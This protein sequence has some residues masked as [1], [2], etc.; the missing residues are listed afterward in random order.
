[1]RSVSKLEDADAFLT[2]LVDALN[3]ADVGILLLDRD[4]RVRFHNQRLLDMFSPALTVLQ[5]GTE[6][7]ELLTQASE[8][9]LFN[10]PERHLARFVDDQVA[11]VRAGNIATAR[12]GF[13]DGR[14]LLFGCAPCGDGGR[15]LTFTDIS[16]ELTNEAA[17]AV[18]QAS[19]DLRYTNEVIES[20]A[21]DL[22]TLAETAHEQA[23]LAER[24]RVRLEHEIEERQKL[25]ADLRRMATVDALTGAMNRAAFLAAG[26]QALSFEHRRGCAVLMLDVDHFKSINDRYGHAGGDQALRHLVGVLRA[27][28]RPADLVGRLGGEEFCIVLRAVTFATAE[29]IAERVRVAVAESSCLH[30]DRRI[31]FTVSIGLALPDGGDDGFEDVIA[32]ADAALYRAKERGRDRV[33]VDRSGSDELSRISA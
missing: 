32:R 13:R 5:P 29:Q 11:H 15:I 12:L 20:Q 23:R 17:H 2:A 6:L 28:T 3:H 30:G 8:R 10:V 24:A 22:V 25:E 7:S 33:E 4:L 27:G 21:A 31:A 19:T 1:M 9:S 16:T 14:R 26:Q 18:E